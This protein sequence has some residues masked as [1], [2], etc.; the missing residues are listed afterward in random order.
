MAVHDRDDVTAR[1]DLKAVAA[2]AVAALTTPDGLAVAAHVHVVDAVTGLA[3]FAERPD[4]QLVLVVV[5][6]IGLQ[7]QSP[8]LG[9]F[10]PLVLDQFRQQVMDDELVLVVDV[11]GFG[12]LRA[13]PNNP[14]ALR[15]V[16]AQ[17]K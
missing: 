9:Q 1:R 5:L 11:D 6:L 2:N 8:Q 13:Y 15:A 7:A 3:L 10:P 17:A 16:R 12:V 4:D 14:A